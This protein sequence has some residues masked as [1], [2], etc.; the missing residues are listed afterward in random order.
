[1]KRISNININ[2]TYTYTCV[3]MLSLC[4]SFFVSRSVRWRLGEGG[5]K[6]GRE[7]AGMVVYQ[8][9]HQPM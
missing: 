9:G 1:M 8:K 4:S 5:R 2:Y 7:G 3:C 6:E